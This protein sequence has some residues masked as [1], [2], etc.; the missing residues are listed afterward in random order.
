M[1]RRE[2]L[3]TTVGVTSVGLAGC[4]GGFG[5][6]E[7]KPLA[8]PPVLDD[9]PDGVYYPTH[10]EGMAGIGTGDAGPF[11]VALSYSYPHRFWTVSGRTVSRQPIRD[12][13]DVHLMATVWDPETGHVIPETSVTAEITRDGDLVTQEVLYPMLSQTMGVHYGDNFD[14]EEGDGEYAITL[15]IGSLSIHRAGAFAGQFDDPATAT[16]AFEYTEAKKREIGFRTT[17]DQAGKAAAVEPM[18]MGGPPLGQ[19]PER[20]AIPGRVLGSKTSDDAVL[21]MTVL[22]DGERFGAGPDD[23]YLA[24]SARTPY[25]GLIIPAMGLAATLRRDGGEIAS[26]RLDRT[27]DPH[28]G[29]HYGMVVPPAVAG[30]GLEIR[31]DLPAQVARHEGYETAFL[32]LGA[33]EFDV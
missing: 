3:G 29:Y 30:D 24:V 10:V 23:A 14:L 27:L 21:T 6:L 13:D 11:R 31:G 15:E 19:A 8:F 7:T 25:N 32:E 17:A 20:E 1:N 28:L 22:D 4:I 16:I 18:T 12:A 26:G 5:G 2:F 33:V 9:R